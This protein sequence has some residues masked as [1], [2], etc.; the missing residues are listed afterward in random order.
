[1]ASVEGL[2]SEHENKGILQDGIPYVYI[3]MIVTTA[4]LKLCEYDPLK[5]DLASGALTD[6]SVSDIDYIR[7]RKQLGAAPS[8]V[9]RNVR[10]GPSARISSAKESTVYV[11]NVNRLEHFLRYLNVD[12]LSLMSAVGV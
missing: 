11:V 2:V 3:A 4:S 12:Q 10:G 1:V 5:I 7:F 8:S 6:A 9:L